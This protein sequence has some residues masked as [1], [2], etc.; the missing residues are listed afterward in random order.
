MTF[1]F[2]GAYAIRIDSSNTTMK[3]RIK[4]ASIAILLLTAPAYAQHSTRADKNHSQP[5]EDLSYEGW[6]RRTRAREQEEHNQRVEH[7]LERQE[8]Q[9]DM[10]RWFGEKR[11]NEKND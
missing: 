1:G 4:A 7:Y 5:Q 2:F 11:Q 10:E 8:R 3:N 9:Q 6:Q